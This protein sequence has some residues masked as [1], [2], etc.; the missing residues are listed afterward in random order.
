MI[1]F[2]NAATTLVKPPRTAHAALR[3]MTHCASPGR[4]GYESSVKAA[5]ILYDCRET[6]ARL[7]SVSSPE[8]V[9]L[10]FNATHALNIAINSTVS[11]G[12]KV[13]ISGYEHNAVLRPLHASGADIK[14]VKTPLFDRSAALD[15]FKKALSEGADAVIC[16][17]VSNVFG[18]ILPVYELSSLCREYGV[19]FI[20]DA[21]QSAGTLD[22]DFSSLGAAAAA[23]P[24]HKGLY[25]MQGTGLLLCGETFKP[26]MYGGTGV[27]SVSP[28]MPDELP[29]RLEAG[30]YCVPGCAA[31][32]EGMRFVQK[33]GTESI[34]RHERRLLDALYSQ[35]RGMKGVTVFKAVDP[36]CQTGVLSL[37]HDTLDCEYIAGRLGE[38]G[39]A[40]RA[41][42]HC[43]PLAHETAGTIERGTVR[44]SF[45]AFNTL[46]ETEIFSAALREII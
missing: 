42:L 23:M 16:T 15:G 10:T 22:I 33:T 1:Y 29:E 5:D 39:I 44:V 2:D 18:F 38:K 45:S 25:G 19:P 3:A 4:G 46:R 11:R 6:A 20:V 30:T 40:V 31:L 21:S 14:I 35:L 37:M 12:M 13:V 41:G 36:D 8:S 26:L 43:A 7:F 32:V 9:V 27:N 34:V 17:H 24:G 28:D